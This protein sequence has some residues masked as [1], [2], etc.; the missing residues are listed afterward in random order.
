[1]TVHESAT[2][3]SGGAVKQCVN[4]EVDENY[5][6]TTN[7]DARRQSCAWYYRMQLRYSYVCRLKWVKSMCP[8]VCF[9]Q[10]LCHD[11]R[12]KIGYTPEA[13]PKAYWLFDRIQ[14]LKPKKEGETVFCRSHDFDVEKVLEACEA[15]ARQEA[16]GEESTLSDDDQSKLSLY[17]RF[18]DTEYP[19]IVRFDATN[20]TQFRELLD[21]PNPC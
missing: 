21:D 2:W 6:D 11:G 1:M 14:Y 15:V 5:F 9:G 3:P 8:V 13:E 4:P 16:N 7:L 18:L 10:R 17:R 20:C 19:G 12:L